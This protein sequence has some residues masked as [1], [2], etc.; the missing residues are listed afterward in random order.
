MA[1]KE[2]AES[3]VGLTSRPMLK[4]NS[5]GQGFKGFGGKAKGS[6]TGFRVEKETA[7]QTECKRR[8]LIAVFI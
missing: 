6:G 2:D 8:R 5:Y 3:V 7:S 1:V 4:I